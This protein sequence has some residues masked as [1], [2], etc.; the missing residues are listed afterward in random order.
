MK[1]KKVMA[2]RSEVRSKTT[3]CCTE[4]AIGGEGSLE[5]ERDK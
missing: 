2:M 5:R 4:I 1:R 3:T